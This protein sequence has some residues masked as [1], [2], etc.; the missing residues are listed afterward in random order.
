M[1]GGGRAGLDQA[2]ADVAEDSL[3]EPLRPGQKET[4]EAGSVAKMTCGPEWEEEPRE[5]GLGRGLRR[6]G[7]IGGGA[8]RREG[9]LGAGLEWMGE[10]GSGSE[11]P[12]G[13]GAWE[14]QV[15]RTGQESVWGDR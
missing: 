11:E 13:E 4:R 12:G 9:A 6:E 14:I 5:G 2:G 7:D 8:S 15:G 10:T 3:P 1:P